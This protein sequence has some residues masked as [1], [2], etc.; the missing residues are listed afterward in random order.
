M[1]ILRLILT[2]YNS[3]T[4]SS[5][6]LHREDPHCHRPMLLRVVAAVVKV[7][8]HRRFHQNT[9][10][11]KSSVTKATILPFS[12]FLSRIP[13]FPSVI[14]LPKDL[15]KKKKLIY[16]PLLFYLFNFSLLVS[17]GIHQ[18][19]NIFDFLGHGSQI[20]IAI[21]GNHKVVFNANTA[22]RLVLVQHFDVDIL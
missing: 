20:D 17:R 6:R 12:F 7:S 19:L 11:K 1:D 14:F 21:L 15:N 10:K 4:V 9:Q 13:P 18:L 5:L 8:N 16:S 2:V 22:D 3:R